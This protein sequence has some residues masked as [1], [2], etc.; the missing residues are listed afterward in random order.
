MY[1]FHGRSMH[2]CAIGFLTIIILAVLHKALPISPWGI[3]L[4]GIGIWILADAYTIVVISRNEKKAQMNEDVS[5]TESSG[6]S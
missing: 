6:E 5:H 2:G 3:L 4:I 1:R